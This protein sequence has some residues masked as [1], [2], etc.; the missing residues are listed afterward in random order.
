MRKFGPAV[1]MTMIALVMSGCIDDGDSQAPATESTEQ[2]PTSE[3]TV[4]EPTGKGDIIDWPQTFEEF[5]DYVYCES[6]GRVCVVDGDTPID[7]GWQ[8]LRE[9]YDEHVDSDG[10]HL[11]LSVNR[12]ERDDDLWY[13]DERFELSFCV[14]DS[15]GDRHREVEE[16]TVDAAR[17]WEVFAAVEFP[18]LDEHNDNC[19]ID[20]DD[21]L[22][23]V[24]PA[25]S[26]APY[27]ARAF[28]PSFQNRDRDVRVHLANIDDASR[29][30]SMQN[31][32]LQGIMRHELGHVLGFRHEHTRSEAGLY[33]C[34]EDY[35]YR[36]GTSY[37]DESLMHYPQCGGANDWSLDFSEADIVGADYFYPEESLQRLGRCDDE[38]GDDGQVIEDCEPVEEQVTEWLSKYGE[39]FV[40]DN[41]MG[42][43]EGVIESIDDARMERPF[44]D[45]DDLRERADMRHFDI[46]DV[47]DYLFVWGRCPDSE[48]DDYG[49]VESTCFPVV[50]AIL[51]LV[52]NA[53]F[54]ELDE[55]V[56][57]DVRGVE[58]I[59]DA[60]RDGPIDSY[61]A[62]IAL[63]YVKR[64]ALFSMYDYLYGE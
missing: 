17:D 26:Q 31:L 14:S 39:P 37:D 38:V 21:V 46:R 9:F 36:P 30:P 6:D 40:L 25:E 22:F 52:N 11:E 18:Y 33:R 48:I 45:Y 35:H 29:N 62:L 4:M 28:F 64:V 56:G 61:E 59:V 13:G 15:F 24:K 50:N 34:F 63:G 49:W 19:T 51:E 57:I 1:L 27:M 23:P 5:L 42:M 54:R 2:L 58:N 47:Y 43:R 53:S 44:E 10:Q 55:D 41:W 32:S 7:G 16:A 8:G 60:R 20:N 12:R 3:S